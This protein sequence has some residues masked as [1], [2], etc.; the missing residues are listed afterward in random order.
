[1]VVGATAVPRG[2]LPSRLGSRLRVL[3]IDE[4]FGVGTYRFLQPLTSQTSDRFEHALLFGN[5]SNR[6]AE[7]LRADFPDV[8]LRRWPHAVQKIRPFTDLLAVL[9]AI[10]EIRRFRPNIIHCHSSKA[11]AL[12][13]IAAIVTGHSS[14]TVYTPHGISFCQSGHAPSHIRLFKLIEWSLARCGGVV[15]AC[16]DSERDAIEEAGIRSVLIRNGTAPRSPNVRHI[17]RTRPPWRVISVG[18]FVAQKEPARFDAIARAFLDRRDV[19]FRWVGEGEL[20]DRL[21]SPNI[22][23]LGWRPSNEVFEELSAA[24]IYCS[25]S[26]S[27]GL[28]LAVLEAMS[29]G[30]PLLLSDCVGNRDLVRS[31]TG[32]LFKDVSSGI[33]KLTEMLAMPEALPE[34]GKGSREVAER[35]YS[36]FAMLESYSLLYEHQSNLT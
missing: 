22:T 34:L 23:I 32:R 2:E 25:T 3:H 5:R 27:E 18:R 35:E 19:E 36:L 31:N 4:C 6:S 29:C 14:R 7:E 9:E 26:S 11:G 12:G 10:Q 1:M 21:T 17:E 20:R 33:R 13:R 24:D 16:S 8:E 15:V 28:P 30:L